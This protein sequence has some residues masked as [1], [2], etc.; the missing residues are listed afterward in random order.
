MDDP[1]LARA[2]SFSEGRVGSNFPPKKFFSDGRVGPPALHIAHFCGPHVTSPPGAGSGSL[3]TFRVPVDLVQGGD[4]G[5]F[6][7]GSIR[8]SQG[9]LGA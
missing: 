9:L 6:E 3:P 7:A 8:L 2:R 1:P 5:S 4:A